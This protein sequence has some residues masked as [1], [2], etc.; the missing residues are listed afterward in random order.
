MLP[1]S[2]ARVKHVAN[3]LHCYSTALEALGSRCNA[4]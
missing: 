4:V 3:A 2:Y 1:L